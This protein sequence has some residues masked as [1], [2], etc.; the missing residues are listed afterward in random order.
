VKADTYPLTTIFGKDVRYVVPLYQRPYVWEEESHWAP[1]WEDVETAVG[2]VLYADRIAATSPPGTPQIVPPPHFL[3]AIVLDLS[4]FAT[5]SI[6]E[7][8]VIDGQ[9]R[10]TTLQLLIAAASDVAAKRSCDREARLL[11]R[12]TENDEDLV[13]QPDDRFKVWPTNYDRQPFRDVMNRAHSKGSGNQVEKAYAYFVAAIDEWLDE[14]GDEPVAPQL[15]ALTRVVRD[16]L[17]LVVIDLE[18][19]DNAQVIFE[20]LNARGMPL[21]AIDLVKNL[22]FQRA[23]K[24]GVN[25]DA[26]Y[27]GQWKSLDVDYWREE[28][29]QGR[30]NRPR[31]ELYLMHW[32]T[33][34][35]AEEVGAHHLFTTF[36]KLVDDPRT[37]PIVEVVHEF[38]TDA[39][40][41]ASFDHQPIGSVE[42]RFFDRLDVLDTSTVLP[43]VLML[44]RQDPV[45]FSEARRHRA[46][47]VLESWLVRRMLLRLTTKNYNRFILDIIK[48]LKDDPTTADEI[49][50]RELGSATAPTTA[51]PTD[52]QIMD[53][54]ADT[55][56]YG[57][58]NQRRVVMV[59]SAVEKAMRSAKS[60]DIQLPGGLTVEH[61]LPQSWKEHWPVDPVDD[62][63]LMA[64]R[65]KHVHRLG[66]LTLVTN[67]LNPA[68]SNSAWSVKRDALN[69]HSVLL[70]N[71]R[72]FDDH[73]V[74]W[75]ESTI[76]Q[77]SAALARVIVDVWPG[78]DSPAWA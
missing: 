4:P 9:Q 56:L 29:R 6:E 17:K 43:I 21:L 51:W 65:E 13:T 23:A 35:R 76:D 47:A 49:I 26:L 58:I 62:S 54:L 24:T 53:S 52:Q 27:E 64:E 12:L 61:V 42:Q 67:K 32:L 34:Q 1:L 7:R 31:A 16:L 20:T 71:R 68:L 55:S 77:R 44:F 33:M 15:A 57:Q 39:A 73:P 70:L 75:G 28:V 37:Q 50:L 66:N 5:G 11:Q 59:L 74:V 41:F 63:T 18:P 10:L 22:V 46:L 60:E 72:L 2:S 48:L 38:A 25:L 69:K 19:E 36:R 45:V 30:L 40:T 8:Y 3:G 78:P 14:D